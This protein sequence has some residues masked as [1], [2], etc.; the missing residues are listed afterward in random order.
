MLLQAA[1][2]G[3]RAPAE[4]PEPDPDRRLARVRRW[5]ILPDYDGEIA[6][7]NLELVRAARSWIS[8]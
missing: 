6:G 4:H 7:D 3:A 5:H 8:G 2:N 1:I